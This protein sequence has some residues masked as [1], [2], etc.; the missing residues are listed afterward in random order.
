MKIIIIRG[1]AGVGKTTIAKELAKAS[2]ADY[3][4]FDVIMK[5][6]KLD[7]I[8]GDGIPA[9]NF[10]KANEILFSLISSK[11]IVVIDGCFYRKKQIDHL[12]NKFKDNVHIFTLD[13]DITE[14]LKR[15]K[16]RDNPMTED[17]IRQVHHLVSNL[18]VGIKINTD[19]K[20][21]HEIVSEI[22]CHLS[23]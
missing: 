8:I 6:N 13:A 4:S 14:C 11:K 5:E 23:K 20:T 10:V 9:E 22:L 16:N 21:I 12:L 18:Q 7:S 1:S 19:S 17:S 15:N 2:K 3:F